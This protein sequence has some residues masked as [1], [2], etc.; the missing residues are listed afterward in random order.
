MDEALAMCALGEH[1]LAPQPSL[2]LFLRKEMMKTIFPQQ[3]PLKDMGLY[4]LRRAETP[5]CF[6]YKG[7]LEG[8]VRDVSGSPQTSV[9]D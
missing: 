5:C 4:A 1:K 8:G 9:G 6:L 3:P 7:V 2:S